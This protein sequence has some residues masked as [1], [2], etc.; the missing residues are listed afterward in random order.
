LAWVAIVSICIFAVG[1]SIGW[2]PIFSLT[3]SEICPTRTRGTIVTV[4]FTY[5]NLLNFGI[6]WGFTNMTSSMGAFG[7]FALFTAF[8]FVALIWIFLEFPECK[9]RSM[10]TMD[11]LF[12]LPWWRM[13]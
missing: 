1:Y 6:T 8:M 2:A 12:D 13:G 5:Q 11:Q 4:V 10:E 3:T 9:G 7:P